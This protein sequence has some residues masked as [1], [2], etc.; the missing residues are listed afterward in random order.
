M[1]RRCSRAWGYASWGLLATVLI[2]SPVVRAETAVLAPRKP[3]WPLK[4]SRVLMTDEEVARVRER[5]RRDKAAADYRDYIVRRVS[6]WAAM[7]AEELRSL[8]PDSRVP[9]AFDVSAKGCPVHGTAIYRHGTYPWKLDPKHPFTVTCP[10]GGERYPSNDFEAYYRG[11]MTDRSLLT[12]SHADDGR[13]WVAPDGEKYWFVAYACHWN[14]AE[15]F[16]PTIAR[17]AEAYVMTGDLRYA[18]SAIAMLDRVAEVYPGMDYSKQSRYAEL[19]RGQY[20]G[21][22]RNAIWETGTL[23]W[24]ARAY[25][26][27]F[28]ALV[29]PNAVSLPWRSAEEIRANIEANLLEEGF[30]AIARGDILG[31]YGSHQESLIT[32]ALARQHGPMGDLIRD[33]FMRTGTKDQ[34]DEGIH[35]ALFNLVDKDGM[36]YETSPSYCWGW[37]ASLVRIAESLWPSGTNLYQHPRLEAMLDAPLRISC[38]GRFTPAIGNAGS[39]TS[40]W[41]GPAPEV[42]DTAYRRLG[43]P[44]YAWAFH[45]LG[46]LKASRLNSLGDLLKEP[47]SA[48]EKAREAMRAYVHRPRSRFLDG[49]GLAI[50]N[51]P[52]DMLAVSMY[53]GLRGGHGD[54]DKLNIELFGQGQRLSPD[55]GYPD[56]MN[57]FVPGIY[58]WSM[59]T[60]SHNCVSVDRT[61][62]T[63]TVASPVLRFHDSPTV[64]VVD[65]DGGGVFPQVDVYRRTLVLVNTGEQDGYLV[66]VFRVR[67]GGEHVLSMHGLEGVFEWAGSELSAPVTEGTCAGRDVPYGAMYDDPKLGAAGYRGGYGSYTGSGYQHFFNWQRAEPSDWASGTYRRTELPPTGLRVHLA[68]HAGQEVIVADAY[69]SPNR[70]IPAVLKYMLARREADASGSTFVT[71][72]EPFRTEPMIDRVAFGREPGEGSDAV[73][74]LE[75]HRGEYV[76]RVLVSPEAGRSFSGAAG[77]SGDAAVAVVTTGEGAWSQVFAAGG[78]KLE[79]SVTGR[80]LPIPQTVTGVV[81]SMD[82]AGRT[83]R[84]V[85]ALKPEDP[86]ALVGL[87]V[88]VYNEAHSCVHKIGEARWEDGALVL[89]VTGSDVYTGRVRIDGVDEE[90]RT[91][92]TAT[93]ILHSFRVAGMHLVTPGR[94]QAGRIIA[95]DK[96]TIH[97]EAGVPMAAF[98]PAGESSGGCDALIADFGV[99][100]RVAIERY[101]YLPH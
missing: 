10:V 70:K 55:L 21:K 18:R 77:L 11:G 49:Y 5:C 101:A 12:G 9:R 43:K 48:N 66:D 80:S 32:S 15:H 51:N 58:S 52:A 34:R 39:I 67:G 76:D 30:D 57:A 14:W 50:L 64:Q 45:R 93:R 95:M 69:V 13:G 78:T 44:E 62:Q 1:M 24:L 41:I 8:L 27:V 92:K 4:T 85:D 87:A 7:S 79:D 100:D 42:Y 47:L 99:G 33:V 81:G 61:R 38:L 65:V 22:I 46:G 53:Y 96:D 83:L 82:Y 6:D 73:V 75:V 60:I 28:D 23:T 37:V 63:A 2:G 68:P 88:R 31:N 89:K 25:D 56:A 36:P 90:N 94:A 97:L 17:L 54:W 40:E 84:V 86:G 19:R 71:V 16:L 74:S 59:H 3:Q 98:A 26:R 91:V 20:Q 29:G 35:Y 72:W